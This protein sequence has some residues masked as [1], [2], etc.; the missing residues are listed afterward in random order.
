MHLSLASS[1]VL[2]AASSS[3][4]QA[5]FFVTAPTAPI[6]ITAGKSYNLT[7][8]ADGGATAK[9]LPLAKE[10]GPTHVGL[11]TGSATQQTEVQQFGTL[12]GPFVRNYWPVVVDPTVGPD[13]DLY[14][15]RFMSLNA[16]DAAGVPL[17]AFSARFTMKGMTGKFTAAMNA[18]NAGIDA[19]ATL[20]SAVPLGGATSGAA[21]SSSTGGSGSGGIQTAGA[22]T[23]TSTSSSGTS[24]TSSSSSSSSTPSSANAS[25]AAGAGKLGMGAGAVVLAAAGVVAMM[26]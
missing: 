17:E 19:A 11:F 25:K 9:A 7:W 10:F 23:V 21:A 16:T 1:A 15:F 6:I 2:L 12:P 18:Q 26:V 14:F 20:V 24:S 3:L 4:V 22:V 13:S 5:S 8:I